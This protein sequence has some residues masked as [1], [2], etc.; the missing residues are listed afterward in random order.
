MSWL[1]DVIVKSS[2]FNRNDPS[3]SSPAGQP[4]ETLAVEFT[5]VAGKQWTQPIGFVTALFEAAIDTIRCIVAFPLGF[6]QVSAL[7]GGSGLSPPAA[8]VRMSSAAS[9]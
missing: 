2:Q 5:T 4:A 9:F 3:P 6:A 8:A 7:G 1:I